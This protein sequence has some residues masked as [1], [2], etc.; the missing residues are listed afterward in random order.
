MF[1]DSDCLKNVAENVFTTINDGGAIAKWYHGLLPASDAKIM[2]KKKVHSKER[3]FLIRLS[4][5]ESKLVVNY[6]DKSGENLKQ[7]YISKSEDGKFYCH[8]T[9]PQKVFDLLPGCNDSRS[10]LY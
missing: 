4:S 8:C 10:V 6:M 7:A 2:L 3:Y 5:S 9:A 1:I